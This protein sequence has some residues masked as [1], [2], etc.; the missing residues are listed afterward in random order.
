M[1]RRLRVR[2][3]LLAA[4]VGAVALAV[5]QPAHAGE[6]QKPIS[7]G[8]MTFGVV[9]IE[10]NVHEAD[11]WL[12]PVYLVNAPPVRAERSNLPA[13]VMPLPKNELERAMREH[14]LS[15]RQDL[16][17]H[18]AGNVRLRR[19]QIQVFISKEF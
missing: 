7:I 12:Y 5:P 14:A 3:L 11:L 15:V 18:F 17:D 4:L 19:N 6:P 13:F 9:G 10:K 2:R 1:D 8:S 16:G